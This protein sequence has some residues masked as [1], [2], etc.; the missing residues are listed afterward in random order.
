MQDRLYEILIKL[1]RKN[2]ISLM[3]GAL[4]I[5]QGYN[6]RT[7]EGCI[8]E[9]MGSEVLNNEKTGGFKYRLPATLKEIKEN[10]DCLGL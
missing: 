6:G 9:A 3:W 4:D 2:L 1:P 7:R 8:L 5:M 10:T